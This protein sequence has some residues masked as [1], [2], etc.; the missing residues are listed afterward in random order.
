MGGEGGV[1]NGDIELKAGVTF[2]FADPG[3]KFLGTYQ[4]T[5]A[6]QLFDVR[7][8]GSIDV[9]LP[10]FFRVGIFST[11][12]GAGHRVSRYRTTICSGDR[13]RD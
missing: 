2:A 5:P 7:L 6:N 13:R 11:P 8:T 10:L 3:R 4:T 1:E 12:R 9:D